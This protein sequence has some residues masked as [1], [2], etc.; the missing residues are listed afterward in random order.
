[1]TGMAR[2]PRKSGNQYLHHKTDDYREKVRRKIRAYHVHI[3]VGIVAQGML[4]YPSLSHPDLI[5]RSFGSW[6]PT[7]RPG[8]LPSEHLVAAAMRS[9][10]P[11]F[12]AVSDREQILAHS[13]HSLEP[14]SHHM[15]EEPCAHEQRLPHT[16][17]VEQ[18]QL[19]HKVG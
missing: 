8:V 18:R 1:M 10:M 15:P 3:T 17:N 13:S 12:L 16:Q 2:L 11:G 7:I 5:W 14:P 4:Q 19:P 9:T 6:V